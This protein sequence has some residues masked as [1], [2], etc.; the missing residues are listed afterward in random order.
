MN[1]FQLDMKLHIETTPGVSSRWDS[2]TFQRV[3]GQSAVDFLQEWD[4]S[5]P[6]ETWYVEAHGFWG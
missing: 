2:A 6:L 5:I 4:T 1:Y 3:A